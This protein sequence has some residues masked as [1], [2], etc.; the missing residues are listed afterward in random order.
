MQFIIE[1]DD[2][3]AQAFFKITPAHEQ[4]SALTAMLTQYIKEKS[5]QNQENTELDFVGMWADETISVDEQMQ[6]WRQERTF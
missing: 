1:V 5:H 3:L 4:K 2:K 6:Q